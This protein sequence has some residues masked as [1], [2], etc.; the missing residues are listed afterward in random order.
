MIEYAFLLTMVVVPG[1]AGIL[2]A[3]VKLQAEYA[4]TRA[5]VLAPTP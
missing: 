5:Q 2:A 3:G 1:A 4:H